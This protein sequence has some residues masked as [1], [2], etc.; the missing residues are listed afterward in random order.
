MRSAWCVGWLAVA[1]T[2]SAHAAP[3]DQ[4]L[5]LLKPGVFLYASPQTGDPNFAETVVMLIQ[6]GPKGAM[7]LVIDHLTEATAED[8]LEEASSLRGLP[9]YWGGPVQPEKILG[10][11]KTSRPSENATRLLDDVYLTGRR[12]DLESAAHGGEAR[13][14]VRLYSGY[15]G[16]GAGQLESEFA[17]QGWVIGPGTAAAVF[18][19]EPR[20]LW[21]KVFRLMD[22]REALGPGPRSPVP[23][24]I[25]EEDSVVT[26]AGA[27]R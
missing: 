26:L 16:W 27:S 15:T 22:R 3:I 4:D 10:I 13:E 5:R 14:R 11:V 19:P 6:Y 21:P 8:V 25:S 9:V 1:I 7:G 23:L 17:R 12:E 18:S 20:K 24:N 2:A